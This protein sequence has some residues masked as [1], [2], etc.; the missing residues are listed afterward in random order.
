MKF[1][2]GK[3]IFN[4]AEELWPINRSI[5]GEGLKKTLRILKREN[6]EL[7][8]LKFK[9]GNKVFDWQIPLEWVINNAYIITPSGSKICD[10]KINN[11][12]LVQYSHAIKK[13]VSL[14]LLK[15]N[16]HYL[17]KQPSAIP[18]V[19]SYYNKKWGF[20]MSYNEY[21][22]LKKGNYEVFI[23]SS[24]KKGHLN[25][26][27][28]I[29]KGKSKEEVFLSTYICHPSMANNE[30]SGPVVLNQITK[31]LKSIKRKYTYRIVFLPETIGSITYLSKKYKTLKKNV[32]AGYNLSCLGDEKNYSFMP[33]RNGQTLSDKV[34]IRVLKSTTTKYKLYDWNYRGSDE[35]QYCSPG[36]DLPISSL[37]KTRYGNYKEYHTSLDKLGTVVTKKGLEESYKLIKD[38]IIN[39]ERNFRPKSVLL[40]EPFLSKRN[41]YPKFT[42][43]AGFKPVV[44]DVLTW[45]DG[46][47][48]IKDISNKLG[49]SVSVIEKTVNIL[50]KHKLVK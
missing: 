10:F 3:K 4:L 32:I 8:I 25:I 46:T 1:K 33:S 29:L 37:M 2:I 23:D 49:V 39:I 36:I 34:A 47:N 41:L 20:C 38:C 5:T 6:K 44:M 7:K 48:D 40:C 11:L 30:L 50:I 45:C 28:I 43:K 16:I 22:K 35:R 26:G 18:Y 15:K 12:H 13:K 14:N 21:K 9:S 19:T 42:S 17:K 24:F 31:W 27:E